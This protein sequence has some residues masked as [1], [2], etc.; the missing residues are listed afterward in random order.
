MNNERVLNNFRGARALVLHAEDAN[1]ETLSQTL[2]R[3]GLLVAVASPEI[4]APLAP[5]LA[6][7]DVLFFDADHTPGA[8]LWENP[9]DVPRIAL[10]GLE[11]PSRLTR[12]VR[13]RSCGYLLK[14]VRSAGVFTALFMGF[15]EFQLRRREMVERADMAERLR[16]RRHVTKAILRMMTQEGIDDDEAYRRLRRESMSR[17]VPIERL[18]REMIE[19]DPAETGVEAPRKL[20]GA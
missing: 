17:R 8:P 18:A 19:T 10:I 6:D 7:C 2:R 20:F 14:P 5:E 3:L 12:V 11:A 13:Q 9:P 4:E 1:R 16:S 15:N